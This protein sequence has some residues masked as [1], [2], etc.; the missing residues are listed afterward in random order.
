MPRSRRDDAE[1]RDRPSPR[2]GLY[3]MSDPGGQRSEAKTARISSATISGASSAAKWPPFSKRLQCTMLE[4]SRSANT[5]MVWK[6]SA[7]TAA[8]VGVDGPGPRW[9]GRVVG[10]GARHPNGRSRTSSPTVR[11]SAVTTSGLTAPWRRPSRRQIG[12]L[13]SQQRDVCLVVIVRSHR[14]TP[15]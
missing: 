11:S 12:S 6:S 1:P 5:L 15:S 3:L 8:L 7:K 4:L 2:R 14:T 10:V 13:R 9:G